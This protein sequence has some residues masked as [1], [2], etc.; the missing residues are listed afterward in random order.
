MVQ[1]PAE[2]GQDG[3]A[4]LDDTPGYYFADLRA[5]FEH[6][7]LEVHDARGER[8]IAV[9]RSSADARSRE[10]DL[11]D[12]CLDEDED[13]ALLP[14]LA[15]SLARDFRADRVRI[16][17]RCGPAIERS[18]LASRMF[19]TRERRTFVRPGPDA[20]RLTAALGE[21]VSDY[22]DGDTPYL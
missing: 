1:T 5:S 11:L 17:A 12:A 4:P 20:S 14:A 3:V 6:R 9:A 15:L 19:V 2:P 18:R 8:G 16:P 13:H 22:C 21:L 10:L 7:L